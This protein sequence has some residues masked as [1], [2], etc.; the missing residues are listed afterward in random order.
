MRNLIKHILM[1][2][3]TV[4]YWLRK[5][6]TPSKS[7]KEIK[8]VLVIDLMGIGDVICLVPFIKSLK[9]SSNFKVSGCFPSS[10]TDLINEFVELEEVIPHQSYYKTI[11]MIRRRKYDL[12][13]IPGW[14]LRHSIVAL[15]SSRRVLGYIVSFTSRY[16]SSFKFQAVGY[17]VESQMIEM[18]DLHLANRSDIIL[19]SLGVSLNDINSFYSSSGK[20]VIIHAGADFEGRRWPTERFASLINLL[21]EKYN[22]QSSDIKLIG[23]PQDKVLNK[24]IQEKSNYDIEDLAG[25]MNLKETQKLIS[26]SLI[27]IGNDSGPMHIAW[28]S[29]IK[30]IALMGPNLPSISGPL[31][32]NSIAL[33]HK[34]PCSPCNQKGCP[35][36][37]KCINSIEVQEV[38]SAFINLVENKCIKY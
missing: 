5:T 1:S 28:M 2:F 35:Y 15:L 23:G 19:E 26:S 18:R 4:L 11:K 9:E 29:G 6:L 3:F 33:F 10:Y 14:A 16:I 20:N 38:A 13:I 17:K 32:M 31:G 34:E 25:R 21:I 37:F 36:N 8:S 7:V 27:F 22:I 24:L 12:I 30:T